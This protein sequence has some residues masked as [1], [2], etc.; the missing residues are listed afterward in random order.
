M[1][2]YR[3]QINALLEQAKKLSHD[4]LITPQPEK[5]YLVN[6]GKYQMLLLQARQIKEKFLDPEE[7][8]NAADVDLPDEDDDQTITP[9]RAAPQQ[10]R[11]ARSRQNHRPRSI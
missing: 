6:V 4:T 5:V 10:D 2:P 3:T 7:N 11:L 1:N 9:R 8:A